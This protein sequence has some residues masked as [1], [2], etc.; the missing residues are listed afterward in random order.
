MP[1]SSGTATKV[2]ACL[3][4][5]LC[6]PVALGEMCVRDSRADC[7][8]QA[9]EG[10]CVDPGVRP[11]CLESC[12]CGSE[13]GEPPA[14]LARAARER[15]DPDAHCGE[16]DGRAEGIRR[17]F[18]QGKLFSESEALV[19]DAADVDLV[20][21]NDRSLRQQLGRAYRDGSQPILVKNAAKA[22]FPQAYE[23]WT[24]QYLAETVGGLP[25]RVRRSKYD[26]G[27][28]HFNRRDGAWEAMNVAEF[29][30]RT[31]GGEGDK[32]YLSEQ[33]VPD[34]LLKDLSMERL[35]PLLSALG[36][37]ALAKANLWMSNGVSEEQQ[38]RGKT[39]PMHHDPYHNVLVMFD[40][41]KTFRAF[42]PL[43]RKWLYPTVPPFGAESSAMN[44]VWSVNL[45][46]FPCFAK[47]TEV[48]L[49][50][51]PGDALLL[52]EGWWHQVSS[53]GPRS[54][55]V[56]FW[57]YTGASA[58]PNRHLA[59]MLG[60]PVPQRPPPP[61]RRVAAA[62]AGSRRVAFRRG[63]GAYSNRRAAQARGSLLARKAAG[64][65][66]PA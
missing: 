55:G 16:N 34:A 38:R 44:D 59:S 42:S 43:Q 9:R 30:R 32:F 41:T 57:F 40:G 1:T 31:D 24:N 13:P 48:V 26:D 7:E 18:G 49:E 3:A 17:Q 22:L 37:A 53:T 54:V 14:A 28:F 15:A 2:T 35:Q 20:G 23:R 64:H 6:L 61:P 56:N 58:A 63:A 33:G 47:A 12:G 65:P 52:P 19:L 60:L 45:T 29:I 46:A 8:G 66:T 39:N 5:V 36:L 10:R 27:V 51:G 25:A 62:R 21:L 4:V 11:A 50:V